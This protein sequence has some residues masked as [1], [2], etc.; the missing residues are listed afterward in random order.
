MAQNTANTKLYDLLISKDFDIEALDSDTGRG[1]IDDDGQPDISSADEFKFDYVPSSGRN[2]GSVVVLFGD[3]NNLTLFFGDNVGKGMEGEDKREWF[4][5]LY[6]LKQFATKNFLDFQP[7]NISKL[8]YSKQSK[9]SVKEGLHEAWQGKGS[10][11]WN[12]QATEARI[13]IKHKKNLEEGEARFRFI[14]SIYI[15]TADNE[16]FKLKSRSLTAAKAMLEHVRQGGNPYDSRAQHINEIVEELSVLSRFRR[17][18]AGKILEGDTKNLVEQT[19]SYYKNMHSI[20]KHLGS[21]RGYQGYFESWS[22]TDVN[23]G[24]LVVEDL[25]QLFVEQSI[26]HRIEEALPLLAR[27]TQE[28]N[29]MK[30]A[31]IFESWVNNLIEGIGALPETPE[32]KQILIDLMSKEFPVGP[33]AMNAKEQL[34]DI[35]ADDVLYDQLEELANANANADARSVILTRLEELSDSSPDIQAVLGQ[36]QTTN[37]QEPIEPAVSAEPAPD[38]EV[39]AQL[40]PG[41]EPMEEGVLGTALGGLVGGAIGGPLGA[42]AGAGLGQAQ[43]QGGSPVIEGSCNST[44]EG[45]Y[46]PE[47][48]LAECGIMEYSGNW[49]NFGLEE[50]DEDN[51]I[52]KNSKKLTD[53]WKGTLAGSAAGGIAGDM[54]GKAI[55]PAAGAALGG[56]IGG[57]AG[58]LAGAAL[59]A[60]AGGPIGSAAGGLAGGKVGDMLGGK[61]ETD[62]NSQTAQIVKGATTAATQGL[63]DVVGG[64]SGKDLL[65]LLVQG[66]DDEL[67]VLKKLALGK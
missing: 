37:P 38:A 8:K 58:A 54:A 11:S 49:T 46:C 13:V 35:L 44:M 40:P 33:E 43:T 57:P 56:A 4:D 20:L 16:R 24:N 9:A 62:E 34:Y 7:S 41:Q 22:P 63:G 66:K 28:S 19:D 12:G 10:V 23:E 5:F 61:E 51:E 25:K 67:N 32:Q 29:K 15:E 21:S 26:D 53:G 64:N 18:N 50:S 45:E 47:H 6:Q 42:I 30:E 48:G 27:I 39:A 17:A 65:N 31:N 14:E 36:L 3:D 52:V 2:Y 55:G 59:G 1:P 60:T